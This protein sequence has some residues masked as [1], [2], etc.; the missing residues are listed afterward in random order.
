MLMTSVE[1]V[2]IGL[3]NIN[4]FHYLAVSQLTPHSLTQAES[5]HEVFLS[6]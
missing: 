2:T 1:I 6:Q 5:R 3:I 4:Y